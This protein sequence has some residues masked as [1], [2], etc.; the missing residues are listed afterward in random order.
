LGALRLQ[1]LTAAAVPGCAK[2]T[3]RSTQTAERLSDL[4]RATPNAVMR[5]AP[6]TSTTGACVAATRGKVFQVTAFF[7]TDF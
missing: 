4:I 7:L 5:Y 2:R 6:T 3:Q 1:T